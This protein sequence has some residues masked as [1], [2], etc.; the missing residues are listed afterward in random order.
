MHPKD[1][2]KMFKSKIVISSFL[3]ILDRIPLHFAIQKKN[4][5][6]FE[7]L[8]TW[9]SPLEK[10]SNQGF[11]PIWYALQDLN[12][13]KEMAIQLLESGASANAVRT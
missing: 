1:Q 5:P 6:L 4:Q 9:K 11:P 7:L 12:D 10:P 2:L 3:Y 13:T 8:L